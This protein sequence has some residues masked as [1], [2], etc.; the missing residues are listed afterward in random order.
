LHKGEK[1]MDKQRLKEMLEHRGYTLLGFVEK[2]GEVIG[3]DIATSE[4]EYN[5]YL[6]A[7]F[8]LDEVEYEQAREYIDDA[9]GEG[10]RHV[11][12]SC[13]QILLEAG[14]WWHGYG[15][16]SDFEYGFYLV[17]L[18]WGSQPVSLCPRC[19]EKLDFAEGDDAEDEEFE[20]IEE[21]EEERP[22][23]LPRLEDPA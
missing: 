4:I 13:G 10:M 14:G 15:P 7:E 3:C 9:M 18:G 5:T 12:H 16:Y 11:M 19:G 22:T 2:G 8:T 20:S 21:Y 1:S 17:P 6:F 23:I